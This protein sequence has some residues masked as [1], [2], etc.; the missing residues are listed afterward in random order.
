M[1]ERIKELREYLILTQLEFSKHLQIQRSHLSQ[2]ESGKVNITDRMISNICTAFNVNEQWLRTGSGKMFLPEDNNAFNEWAKKHQLDDFDK[3]IMQEY[4][5]LSK[6]TRDFVK[7]IIKSVSAISINANGTKTEQLTP[8]EQEVLAAYRAE[9][10]KEA[11]K[12]AERERKV[13][14][15]AE[16]LKRADEIEESLEKGDE[17]PTS[18]SA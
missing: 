2:I 10:T 13:K 15:Y 3:S 4:C 17:L 12:A 8:D 9:Q 11:A 18:I 16:A 7:E 14:N 1:N 6:A 5:M